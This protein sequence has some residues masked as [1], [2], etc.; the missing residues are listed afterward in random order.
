M[1]TDRPNKNERISVF[2]DLLQNRLLISDLVKNDFKTKYAGSYFGIIWA[3]IQPV[4][5]VLVYWFVF[6]VAFH[7]Q[8]VD[9]YPFV[10]WLV[11][12][13]VP[14]FFF[15]DALNSGSLAF[16]DYSYLVK[17]VVFRI[18]ILPFVKVGSALIVHFVFLAFTLLLYLANGFVPDLY[19]LQ[20]LY[21]T[22]A[23]FAFSV[24]VAYVMSSI[25]VFFKDLTQIIN[26]ILQVG[27]WVTPILW[28]L[29][30]TPISEPLKLILMLNPMFYI[31]QGY[32]DSLIYKTWFWESPNLTI[33]FWAVT[34][35]LYVLGTWM[36]KRLKVHFADVL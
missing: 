12:G 10:L 19:Y 28:N 36:F 7:S 25:V 24:S 11:A 4:V 27:V 30:T 16:L 26:I 3:F 29:S 5:T 9:N 2:K 34:I 6:Q 33:Y 1:K 8:P 22:F 15:S 14:W 35:G 21:Y 17:K 32:R 31:T 13:L 20:I 23:L 18:S